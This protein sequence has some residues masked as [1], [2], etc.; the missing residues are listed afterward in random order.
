MMSSFIVVHPDFD[1]E[2][3]LAADY[4]HKLWC[5]QDDVSFIRLEYGDNRPLGE[6][7]V[8][9]SEITRL[10]S[11]RVPVTEECLLKFR[12]LKE[13][14]FFPS[15]PQPMLETMSAAGVKIYRQPTEGYWGQSVAEFALALTICGLRRIPQLH[16]EII[17]SLGPWSYKPQGGQER[18]GGR[19]MQLGDDLRFANGTIEG[20]RVRLVGIGNIGSR[21][22]SFVHMLGA[23]VAAWDPFA[24]EPSF[25]RSGARKEWHLDQLMRDADIFA[26]MVPLTEKTRRII[27]RDHIN[28][29]PVGCLVVLVTRAAICDMEALRERVL[30]DELS[31]AADVFDIEPLP[32]NDPLLGRNNVVHTP[33]NAGRTAHANKQWVEKLAAQF[34]PQ[35]AL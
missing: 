35:P 33:H 30:A 17:R 2:W 13:A 4:F 1:G 5:M 32:L 27:T 16:H 15:L 9:P 10:V 3:P 20:K 23:N 29:L 12:Q 14:V 24:S 8:D 31:L 19:G 21:Y 26:P 6:I 28:S 18:P 22:A 34:T 7:A 11:L 25:H